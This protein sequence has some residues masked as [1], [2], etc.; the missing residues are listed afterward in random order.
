M[1]IRFQDRRTEARQ[2]PLDKINRCLKKQPDDALSSLK[3]DKVRRWCEFKLLAFHVA[4]I[5]RK[6]DA[7]KDKF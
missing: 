7:K 4:G 5:S 3:A 6:R 1:P 2:P